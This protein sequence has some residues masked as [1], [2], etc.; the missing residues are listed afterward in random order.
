M[1]LRSGRLERRV[2]V[3]VLM[4]IFSLQDPAGAEQTTTENVCSLGIRV[5][6]QRSKK[7]QERLMIHS[8][9]GD[10]QTPARVVY[11]QRLSDGRFAVGLEFQGATVKWPKE[12][13]AGATG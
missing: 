1:P 10:V 7:P 8:L 5:L 13:L 2:R 11:C 9:L 6:L 12:S 3:A 4:E